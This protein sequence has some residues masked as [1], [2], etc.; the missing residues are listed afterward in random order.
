MN[1]FEITEMIRKF[2]PDTYVHCKRTAVLAEA[3]AMYSDL[4]ADLLKQAALIHDVGKIFVNPDI[5]HK[6]SCLTD[7]ERNI[8]DSHSLLGY[9]YYCELTEA[10][11][12]I[13]ILILFHHGFEKVP[14]KYHYLA[15]GLEAEIQI[16]KSIDVFDALTSTRPYRKALPEEKVYSIMEEEHCQKETIE[17]IKMLKL[18]NLV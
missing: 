12:K 10:D 11:P 1:L 8:I 18:H 13:G 7:E 17:V 9:Q 5:L 16:M 4:D 2:D 6:S 14:E 3:V 15:K